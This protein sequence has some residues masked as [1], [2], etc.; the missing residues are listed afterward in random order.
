MKMNIVFAGFRHGHIFD[1]WNKAKKNPDIKILGA[2][3]ENDTAREAAAKSNGVDFNYSTYQA[4]LED[5][6]VDI[7][8]IGDYFGKRGSLAIKALRAG[9]HVM[10]D[11]PLCTS[12]EELDEIEKLSKEKNLCVS[13]MYSMRYVESTIAVKGIIE[14]GKLGKIHSIFFSGQHPL[15]YGSRPAWYYEDGKHGGVIN[16]IGIHGIDFIEYTMGLRPAKVL[17]AREWNA[18]ATAEPHFKDSAQ[19]MIELDNGAGV[20]ADVSYAAPTSFSYSLPTYWAFNIWGSG[21][22]IKFVSGVNDVEA[23]FEGNK[24]VEHIQGA[25]IES[26]YITDILAEINGE[27]NSIITTSAVLQSARDTLLIQKGVT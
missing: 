2:W 8:A 20:I 18:F 27:G 23:Y 5:K 17:A 26:D 6:S 10:V 13:C 12:I 3:E 15:N 19:F 22:M 25:A 1:L 21:G 9:K 16:D 4:V 24:E 14:S 11:K 7:I